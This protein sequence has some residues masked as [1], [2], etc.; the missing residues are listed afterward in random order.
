M[1]KGKQRK[2]DDKPMF[3]SAFNYRLIGVAILLIVGGFTAMYVE[4][5][6][7]GF[8]SL[9]ISPIVIMAGY[10]VV[11]FAIMKHDRDETEETDT[12]VAT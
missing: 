1:A 2:T 6:V 5:E 9:Y 10:I 12:E 11:I 7:H 8:I 3:F 4:N